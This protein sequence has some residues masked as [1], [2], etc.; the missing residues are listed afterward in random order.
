MPSDQRL[1]ILTAPSGSGK[2]TIVRHLL[3][4]MPELSFSVS[5]CTRS[6]RIGETDGVNYF[7]ITAEDFRERISRS[8]FAEYEMVYEGKYYGTLKSEL[9]RIWNE[10]RFPLIDIDVH[11]ALRLKQAYGDSALTLFIQAPSMQELERRLRARGTETEATLRERL[12]K[13]EHE[14]SFAPRF[15][16]ILVNDH[17][18]RA[19]EE[20]VNLLRNFLGIQASGKMDYL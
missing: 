8:E 14:L 3:M 5:A 19:C 12:G 20:A 17:L 4:E 7:F 1:V 11:G 18:D 6:P 15:D 2:T 9:Q 16:R 10:A 13:A